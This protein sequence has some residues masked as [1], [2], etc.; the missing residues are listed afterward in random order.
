MNWEDTVMECP[1]E[2]CQGKWKGDVCGG[3]GYKD[4]VESQAKIT[5]DI[6]YQKGKEDALKE[7]WK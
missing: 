3:C 4:G 1:V 5:W 6:A 2:I 7:L